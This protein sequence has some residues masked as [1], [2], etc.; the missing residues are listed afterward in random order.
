MKKQTL[1]IVLLSILGSHGIVN[2]QISIDAQ[3]RDRF[4]L[5]D[6]Y[7]KLAAEEATPTGIVS[8]RARIS[9]SYKTDKLTL[10]LTPQDV[11]IWGADA[12]WSSS[13]VAT[14]NSIGLFEGYAEIKPGENFSI[15]AGRQAF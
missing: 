2:A 3:F 12:M 4:E 15:R 14:N 8:Q 6:G 1:L 13:G 7:K 9:F 11:R 5:R 10:K